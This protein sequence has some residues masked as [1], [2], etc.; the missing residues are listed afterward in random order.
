MQYGQQQEH[1]GELHGN[2]FQGKV[3][4]KDASQTSKP[5]LERSVVAVTAVKGDTSQSD[6]SLDEIGSRSISSMQEER[7]K[8]D[9]PL[10]S[11]LSLISFFLSSSQRPESHPPQ[12]LPVS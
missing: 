8:K 10:S 9:L 3:L 12:R 2:R 4:G 6:A 7:G 5:I 1:A 11:F